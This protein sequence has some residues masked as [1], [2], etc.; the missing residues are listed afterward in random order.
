MHDKGFSLGTHLLRHN[1]INTAYL[2]CPPKAG[3]T[4]SLRRAKR[5]QAEGPSCRA[6]HLRLGP[7][8]ELK[9]EAG[10]LF[11]AGYAL[12]S[13]LLFPVTADVVFAPMI[14]RMLHRF[15]VASE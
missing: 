9:M 7:V 1:P 5:G 8:T 2:G 14:H 6:R 4:G 3:V 11:A 10:K 12:Y 15:P 13:G